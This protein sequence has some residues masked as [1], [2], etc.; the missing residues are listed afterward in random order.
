MPIKQNDGA[1]FAEG[2][3]YVT[4][5]RH[6]SEAG[7]TEVVGGFRAQLAGGRSPSA[8]AFRASIRGAGASIWAFRL[9]T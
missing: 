6:R 9:I 8:D 3:S 2:L 5:R 1:V 4:P 7:F